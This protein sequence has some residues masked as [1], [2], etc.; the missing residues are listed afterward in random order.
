M[1]ISSRILRGLLLGT[2][3][4]ALLL[5]LAEAG[6]RMVL[7]LRDGAWPRTRAAAFHEEV[8]RLRRIYRLHAY[9][10]TGPREGGQAAVFGKSA[11]L[12]RLGY[13]SPERPLAKPPGVLRVL[14]AGGSTTFDVLADDDAAA[15]PNRLEA[16]LRSEGRPVEVWNAG[17]PG[18]TSQENVISL[19]IRDLDLRPDLAV[20]YQGINDLQPASHQPFDPQ[21]ER[22]HAEL[23]RRALGLELPA[24]SWLDRSL[25]VEKLRGPADPWR[26][27]AAPDGG[28]RRTRISAEGIAAFE[29]N[30]RSFAALARS[31]GADVLLVTQPARI[32]AAHRE[33]DLAY[34]AGWYPELAPEAVPA[35]LER[36]NSVLRRLAGEGVGTL[37]DAAREIAWEDEDFGD[38]LHYTE[39]GRRKLVE[40]LG[41]RVTRTL[42]PTLSRPLPPS[43][44]GR[45]RPLPKNR[46]L[47]AV[48]SSPGEGGREGSGEEG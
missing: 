39:A 29:R 11:S 40:Y 24:P 10:N 32:R 20:L 34:L 27:L 41:P 7:R 31:R 21:Y 33:A 25:L 15:W 38:P 45:G 48:P 8:G 14:V 2:L 26:S 44:T 28:E 23:S 4:A 37:A 16:R 6:L 3:V 47:P 17:F 43:L 42:T 12:N 9:L 22:G 36:L 1:K 19:A 35:E 5:G 13:R 18:W 46:V 30:V